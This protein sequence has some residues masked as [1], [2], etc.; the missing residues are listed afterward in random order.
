MNKNI[1]DY[2]SLAEYAKMNGRNPASVR[3]KVLRGGFKT[4]RKIGRSWL[5]SKSEPY[6]DNR[7]TSGKY[8]NWRKK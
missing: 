2:I 8:R 5:I 1:D 3:Q 4:A 7:I 6:E